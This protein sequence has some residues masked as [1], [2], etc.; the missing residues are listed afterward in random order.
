[1]SKMITIIGGYHNGEQHEIADDLKVL[2]LVQ[3]VIGNHRVSHVLH[4]YRELTFSFRKD[5]YKGLEY[6][7]WKQLDVSVFVPSDTTSE[8]E[9]IYKQLIQSTLDAQWVTKVSG[10]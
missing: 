6:I 5:G 10:I 7:S 2:S 1:M 4:V 8:E 3:E 9:D